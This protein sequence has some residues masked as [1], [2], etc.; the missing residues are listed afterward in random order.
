[1]DKDYVEAANWYRKAADLHYAPAMVDIA[2]LY[3]TGK[4]VEKDF[5]A[6]FGWYKKAADLNNTSRRWWKIAAL[7]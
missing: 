2:F 5:G 7:P 4:G 3:R 6:A 1:M